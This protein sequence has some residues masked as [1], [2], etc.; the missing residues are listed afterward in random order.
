MGRDSSRSSSTKPCLCPPPPSHHPEIPQR[1]SRI[2]CRLEELGL[3][4]RCLTLPA[5]PAT[6]A[7]LLTCHRSDPRAWGRHGASV[8]TCHLKAGAWVH[9]AVGG[10]GRDHGWT[11]P[12]DSPWCPLCA[13][14]A[15][16][17]GRLRATE[18]MKTREL[19]RESANFESIYICP[20]TFACAQLATGASCC[21]VEAVL[22]GEV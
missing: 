13:C 3:A 12:P 8:H 11:E 21:L 7:E 4:G 16:Y 6:D 9:G 2:M 19:H 20:S 14:S 15:E 22:A 1:V 10:H 18:K 5:R 17:V